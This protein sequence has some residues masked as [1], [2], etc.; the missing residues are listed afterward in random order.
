[1]KKGMIAV[2]LL[3]T[4]FIFLTNDAFAAWTQAKGHSYNQL[5]LSHYRTTQKFTTLDLDYDGKFIGLE[6]DVHLVDTEQFTSTKLSYYGEYGLTD[7]ITVLISGGWDQ[8]R[9]NDTLRYADD[10]GPSGIGDIIIGARHK[11]ADNLFGTGVVMSVQA[12]VSI[13]EAYNYGNPVTEL[14]QGSGQYDATFKLQFGRGLGKG[15]MWINTDYIYRFENEQHDPLTFKPAD[16]FKFSLGGGYAVASWV[17]IRGIISYTESLGNVKVSDELVEAF[18]LAGGL[19]GQGD[20]VVIK[21]SLGL[22]PNILNFGID[23]A[24]NIKPKWQTVL[25]YSRDIA[26]FGDITTK[27]YSLGEVFSLS[28]VYMH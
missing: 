23:F 15:Y 8:Q 6:D 11:V 20:T 3:L 7:K 12:E 24:F 1:M 25:S 2:L 17:S 14:S 21:D 4:G 28:L 13:P 10:A 27:D 9:S 19:I 26:G 18:Y 22:S 16:R 5:T